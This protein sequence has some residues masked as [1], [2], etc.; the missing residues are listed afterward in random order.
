MVALARAEELGQAPAQA[1]LYSSLEALARGLGLYRLPC[2]PE[3]PGPLRLGPCD[4]PL[5]AWPELAWA[6]LQER[7]QQ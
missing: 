2:L 4:S 7:L 5:V 6:H 1:L 3:A